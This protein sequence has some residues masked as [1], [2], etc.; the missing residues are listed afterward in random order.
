M[1]QHKLEE[2]IDL[3]AERQANHRQLNIDL[4][5]LDRT[6]VSLE[7]EVTENQSR[8]TIVITAPRSG[9][10]STVHLPKG[11]AV[12]S[13]QSV[14]TLVPIN[15]QAQANTELQ[16]HLYA[17]SRTAGFVKPGQTVWLSYGAY[18]YQKFGLAQGQ[19]PASAPHQQLPKTCQMG[20]AQHYKARPEAR[21]A[22]SHT[23]DAERAKH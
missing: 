2:M 21:A 1:A 14:T 9:V 6:L 4:S 3:Q 7:Q 22:V 5:Q 13:G 12:Q 8:K 10:V 11:A 15:R 20:R 23:C 16:A 18:P 17:P 19:A